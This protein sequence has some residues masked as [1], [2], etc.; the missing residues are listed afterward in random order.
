MLRW[1][2]SVQSLRNGR[3]RRLFLQPL[4]VGVVCAVLICLLLIMGLVDLR[5]LD[6]TLVGYFE[7][8]GLDIVRNVQQIAERDF[9]Q[10]IKTG[11]YKLDSEASLPFTE[12]V[13]FLRDAL[14]HDLIELGQKIDIGLK[15]GTLGEKELSSLTS[16]EGLWLV[17]L[18]ND[19]GIITFRTRP[20]PIGILSSARP[21]IQGR[22]G[23]SVNI[24][25]G[26]QG[27]NEV[28]SI[29][30]RRKSGKG[31]IILAL[32]N[33]G[34]RYRCLRVSVQTA[35]DEFGHVP[36]VVGLM[37][38]D[39]GDRVL[40]LAGE[41]PRIRKER[42]G[43]WNAL[44]GRAGMVSRKID[45]DGWKYLE[46]A[47]PI[48][49]QPGF[50][51]VVLLCFE[52]DRADEILDKSKWRVFMSMVF[53]VV[54]SLISMWL[55]YKNQN[56]HLAGI[57][58]M[59]MRLHQAERLSAMGRLAAGVA[60]EIR[61]PLN[62]ISMAT[63]RL[64]E[65][66]VGQLTGVILAEIRRLNN[67]VEEF[68]GFSRSRNLKFS[69]LDLIG[70]LDQIVLLVREEA[71]SEGISI[72]TRYAVFPLMISMDSDK[73]EQAFLN[74]IKNAMESISDGGSVKLSVEPRGK[75]WVTIKISDT[76]TGLSPEEIERIFDPDYTTKEKGLGLGLS[77]AHEII[78]G[79]GGE[80]HVRSQPGSGTTFEILLPVKNRSDG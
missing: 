28:R 34:F 64:Q 12:E 14:V 72:E 66:N 37:V 30:F 62:A 5:A 80:I 22:T 2:S 71:E 73:L 49:I 20:V 24:F 46:I 40:G 11:S 54:I 42:P 41:L 27:N 1:F 74:I 47:V 44:E 60:H 19:R 78:R 58:E 51:G 29:V 7:S 65:N 13:F 61:N 25:D 38:M 16:E 4:A 76:G 3:E 10:L 68:L 18:L 17:A 35:I 70:L 63:Q 23:I 75:E 6:R 36:G 43:T 45:R 50:D 77:L 15:A 39:H 79:H 69:R 56:R 57:Q 32:D 52:R 55:L 31:A 59:E 26:A 8:R 21:V 48:R 33:K 9:Q 67:I 53:M